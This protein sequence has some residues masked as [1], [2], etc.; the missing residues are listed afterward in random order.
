MGQ[1]AVNNK[2]YISQFWFLKL[3]KRYKF[4]FCFCLK[5]RYKAFLTILVNI[6]HIFFFYMVIYNEHI[7][8][9]IPLSVLS[10]GRNSLT[11]ALQILLWNSVKIRWGGWC[12]PTTNSQKYP[13]PPRKNE[14]SKINWT[15]KMCV[16]VVVFA[17]ILKYY[18]IDFW[19]F[20]WRL[21]ILSHLLA[22]YPS[23][24]EEIGRP[25]SYRYAE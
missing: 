8:Q 22:S 19:L 7:P 1:N 10:R 24:C 16:W 4:K 15:K 11:L 2:Q 3:T 14:T 12:N 17:L 23:A 20:F 13:P 6:Y 9:D 25:T 5:L 18:Q 21:R